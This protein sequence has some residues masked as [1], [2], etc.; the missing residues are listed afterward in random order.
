MCCFTT[1]FLVLASRLGILLWWLQNPE[2]HNLPFADFVLPGGL[3]FP[4]W[5]WTLVGAIFLPWTTLAY[6][7]LYPGGIEGIKWL[8]LGVALLV[9]LAGHGGS[10]RHRGRIPYRR[11]V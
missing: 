10:Y 1:I 7:L 5:L 8:I 11:G 2:A 6:L 4:G 3:S 9:D